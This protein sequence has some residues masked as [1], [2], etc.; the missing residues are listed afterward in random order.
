VYELGVTLYMMLAG[1]L[2][3]GEEDAAGSRLDPQALPRP[4]GKALSRV[5][6]RAISTRPEQRFAN[7]GSFRDAVVEAAAAKSTPELPRTT[8]AEPIIPRPEDSETNSA[9][10]LTVEGPMLPMST[11]TTQP[12]SIRHRS[13]R[14]PWLAV[15]AAAVLGVGGATAYNHFD[16]AARLPA[17][18]SSSQLPQGPASPPSGLQAAPLPSQTA[19][20]GAPGPSSSPSAASSVSSAA[21]GR[22]VANGSARGVSSARPGTKPA[23]SSSAKTAT[24]PAGTSTPPPP[25]ADVYYIDRR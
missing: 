9:A 23:A 18:G 15:A 10:S 14:L 21:S 13:S 20:N 5:V 12:V 17:A 19:T 4:S 6:M 11:R 7:A 2:P 24:P 1:R 16:S 25:S 3:W 8:D 22:P